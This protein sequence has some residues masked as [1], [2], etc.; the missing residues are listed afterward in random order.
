MKQYWLFRR[1][2]HY[3]WNLVSLPKYNKF[4]EREEAVKKVRSVSV[5]VPDHVHC[6]LWKEVNP[7]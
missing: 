5:V 1:K 7:L 3:S 4:G 2:K 6:S